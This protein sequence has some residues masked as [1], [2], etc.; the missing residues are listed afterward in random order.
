MKT[1]PNVA[2]WARTWKEENL[3]DEI[4]ALIRDALSDLYTGDNG[5]SDHWRGFTSACDSITA[6][7]EAAPHRLWLDSDSGECFE[8]EPNCDCDPDEIEISD[9]P[10]DE[11]Y[12]L[13][14]RRDIIRA[15][16]GPELA[17]YIR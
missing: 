13:I 4:K 7:L 3:S 10:H 9:C 1:N 11:T 5:Y 6:A 8:S 12:Y 15:L 14:E 16:V 17:E 2:A